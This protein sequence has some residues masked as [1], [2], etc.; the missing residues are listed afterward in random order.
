[1]CKEYWLIDF[2]VDWRDFD[3]E[4]DVYFDS[5]SEILSFDWNWNLVSD[6]DDYYIEFEGEFDYLFF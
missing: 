5:D 6:F 2:F 4:D 3:D 1:M